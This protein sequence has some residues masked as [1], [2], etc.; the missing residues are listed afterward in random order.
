MT[1]FWNRVR[2]FI[3]FTIPVIYPHYLIVFQALLFCPEDTTLSRH[4][5]HDKIF[6]FAC[7][8]QRDHYDH[9]YLIKG[10]SSSTKECPYRG[11]QNHKAGRHGPGDFRR[12]EGIAMKRLIIGIIIIALCLS[13]GPLAEVGSAGWP[14]PNSASTGCSDSKC[15]CYKN[16]TN[17]SV[18]KV[19]VGNCWKWSPP[20]CDLCHGYKGIVKECNKKY[21]ECNNEC[22][23]SESDC[24]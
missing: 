13:L 12:K 11:E 21:P 14:D 6:C 22:Y 3:P 16:N 8:Y 1:E 7:Q 24:S 4:K 20:G 23:S 15:P 17:T 10:V 5:G 9:K 18:G 2:H 19:T